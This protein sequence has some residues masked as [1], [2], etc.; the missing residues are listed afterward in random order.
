[1]TPLKPPSKA[2][3]EDKTLATLCKAPEWVAHYAAWQAAYEMYRLEKG[4]PWK[5][6]PAVFATDSVEITRI[7][8]AQR[9][10]YKSRSS[11]GPLQ[12]I[13]RTP[14]LLCCPMCGS[15]HPGTL[16]HYLPRESFPELSILPCNLIPACPHCN[17]GV[18]K[19]LYRGTASPERF[20]H[21]YFETLAKGPIWHVEI[22]PPFE[23]ARFRPQV[24]DS[25]PSC[26]RPMVQF[27][28]DHILGEVFHDYISTQWSRLP[29][30]IHGWA[31]PNEPITQQSVA[32]QLADHLRDTAVT[33]GGNGWRTALLRGVTAS[34]DA[35]VFLAGRA[36]KVAA[37]GRVT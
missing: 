3:Q 31:V 26:D 25:V 16:D 24:A 22:Q 17:S 4:D 34:Q 37:M 29:V 30:L 7:A 12:R 14:G 5:I 9:A 33:S 20:I 1:M 13:R 8:E 19:G 35:I 10:F 11:S 36:T 15:Q 6:A 27:H 32:S 21:P 18:K 23:A 2:E 28:L